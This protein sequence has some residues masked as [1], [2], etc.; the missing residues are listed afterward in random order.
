LEFGRI[1]DVDVLLEE[2]AGIAQE[3]QQPMLEWVLTFNRAMRACIAG[4]TDEAERLATLALEIATETG[5]PDGF[6]FYGS[7]LMA[8]RRFEGRSE[9]VL[10]IIAQVA[11]DNPAMS[12]FRAVLAANQCEVD[13]YGDARTLLEESY[14]AGFDLPRDATWSTAMVSWAAVA[15]D[16]QHEDVAATL[17]PLLLP[18][19]EHVPTTSLNAMPPLA[20]SLGELAATLGRLEDAERHFAVA[21]RISARLEAPYFLARTYLGWATALQRAGRIDQARTIARKALDQSQG[22]FGMIDRRATVLVN[23]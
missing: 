18:F 10:P 6:S 8:I 17:Y 12:V 7:Q 22:R 15:A 19:E 21:E 20:V 3:V 4:G 23:S 9:E 13:H 11:A 5:Q 2:A 1:A 16:L 14:R